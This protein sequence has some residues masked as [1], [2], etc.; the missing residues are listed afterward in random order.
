M[1]CRCRQVSIGHGAALFAF[2]DHY[3]P[4]F[5][6]ISKNRMLILQ[7]TRRWV[8]T[9]SSLDEFREI[10]RTLSHRS[11]CLMRR[12]LTFRGCFTRMS[13]ILVLE[14]NSR[15]ENYVLDLP[16]SKDHA[17]SSFVAKKITTFL[18]H[19]WPTRFSQQ[20]SRF[21]IQIFMLEEVPR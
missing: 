11:L 9:I 7:S 14:E 13:Y 6:M 17:Y 3:C 16:H 10:F 19:G 21:V 1:A 4:L 20:K 15:C 12:L 5:L 18:V 2:A 8:P